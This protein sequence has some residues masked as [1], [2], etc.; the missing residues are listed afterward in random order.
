MIKGTE[1][2][3]LRWSR[4]TNGQLLRTG[5]WGCHKI[6]NDLIGRVVYSKSGRD[7][8][9]IMVIIDRI[10]DQYWVVADG[11]LRRVENP[12]IKNIKHLQLTRVKADSMAEGLAR[13]E[14]PENHVIRNYLA[15]LKG[16]GEI[17][18]KEG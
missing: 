4:N 3:R 16:T 7:K 8:G 2:N 9:R 11:D 1:L 13:G 10:N 14:L 5:V 6:L 15:A 17:V 18:G 12:K